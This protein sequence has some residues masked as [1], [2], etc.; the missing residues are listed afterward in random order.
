MLNG[1][2]MTVRPN[3]GGNSEAL[4]LLLEGNRMEIRG[5]ES[6]LKEL[7]PS[8]DRLAQLYADVIALDEFK[9]C[10][11]KLQALVPSTY[12]IP[13]MPPP[14]AEEMSLMLKTLFSQLE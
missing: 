14:E 6:R 13:A 10:R 8:V 5:Y 2:G 7:Q 9:D 4:R 3:T 12:E 1:N 11:N